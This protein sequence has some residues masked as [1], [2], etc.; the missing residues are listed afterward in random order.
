[1]R[2]VIFDEDKDRMMRNY[3]Y[4]MQKKN[5]VF[6]PVHSAENYID[7]ESGTDVSVIYFN[8]NIAETLRDARHIGKAR[9]IYLICEENTALS[10]MLGFCL[11]AECIDGKYEKSKLYELI[12]NDFLV[13]SNTNTDS[14]IEKVL[15]ACHI[16]VHLTG[17]LYMKTALEMCCVNAQMLIGITKILYPSISKYHRVSVDSVERAV[18]IAIDKS[19]SKDNE[20]YTQ[21]LNIGLYKKPTNKEF[22]AAAVNYIESSM[23]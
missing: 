23:L 19:W 1:M 21:L 13:N 14:I 6:I 11:R 17:R 10:Y 4:F 12:V 16:P 9:K 20:G 18:R 2:V 22:I 7:A 15:H 8:E 3:D 5:V